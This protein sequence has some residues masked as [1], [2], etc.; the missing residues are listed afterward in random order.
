M[1]WL[2]IHSNRD[3]LLNATIEN[4]QQ[5]TK[6]IDTA[7]NPLISLSMYPVLDPQ[8]YQIMEKDYSTFKYPLYEREKDFDIINGKIQNNFF[9]YSSIIESVLIYQSK[10][11]MIV[12]AAT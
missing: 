11:N 2:F 1:S 3:M 8:V 12:A 10:N 4:N 5:I 9:L 7:L 6:N